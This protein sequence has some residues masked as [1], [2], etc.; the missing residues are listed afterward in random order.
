MAPD[1][2][3]VA[4]PGAEARGTQPAWPGRHHRAAILTLGLNGPTCQCPGRSVERKKERVSDNGQSVPV[5]ATESHCQWQPIQ[6]GAPQ[7]EDFAELEPLQRP[8]A[9]CTN[10]S[11]KRKL[12]HTVASGALIDAFDPLLRHRRHTRRLQRATHRLAGMLGVRWRL[13]HSYMRLDR[14]SRSMSYWQLT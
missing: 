7:V 5:T 1:H 4:A 14:T 9:G 12:D 11:I 6:S 8:S 2:G 10:R 13:G 3:G